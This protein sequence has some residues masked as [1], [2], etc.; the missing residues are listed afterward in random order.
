MQK[1]LN[2]FNMNNSLTIAKVRGIKIRLHISWILVLAVLTYALATGFFPLRYEFDTITNWVLG[3]SSALLLFVSVFIHELAHSVIAQKKGL[4]VRSIT[5]FFF[6]GLANIESDPEKPLVEFK[7]SIG[8]PLA[9]LGLG[10][11]FYFLYIADFGLYLTPLFDYLSKINFM[12]AIFNMIPAFPLDGGRVF[13]SI[14]WAYLDDQKKATRMA[15]NSG[16]IF[17]GILIALGIVLFPSGIWFV[18][19][20]LFLMFLAETG[21]KQVLIKFALNKINIKE[22]TS[23][24][25]LI[26]P[27][28]TIDEY[29]QWCRKENALAGIAKKGDDYFAVELSNLQKINKKTKETPLIKSIMTKTKT[30]DPEKDEPFKLFKE[31]QTNNIGIMPVIENGD[32]IGIISTDSFYRLIKVINLQEKLSESFPDIIKPANNNSD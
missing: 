19:M 14:L 28:W 31:M 16:K 27:D 5:L 9:S 20:G 17:G 24:R 11:L 8:G 12:L 10:V 2:L 22:L 1:H 7:I 6:G 32:Y 4:G 13:R 29:L 25:P 30:V 18:F 26:N 15:S 23:E 21:Y 3:A